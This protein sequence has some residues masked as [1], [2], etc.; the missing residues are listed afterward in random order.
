MR[1]R[2]VLPTALMFLTSFVPAQA[3]LVQQ[4]VRDFRKANE[5]RL[6]REFLS[7]LA[8]PNIASD[9]A[10]IRKNAQLLMEMMKSRGLNP[11]LLE[12]Q[13]P[14][15]PPAVFAEWKTPGATRTV[16][17]YAHYDG[18]PTDPKQWTGTQPWQPVY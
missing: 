12:A 2:L 15:T 11:R 9:N 13:T 3:Q 18:Q 8:I 4:Q 6:L 1:L 7:F 14:N 17:L 10:N 5:H 16:I